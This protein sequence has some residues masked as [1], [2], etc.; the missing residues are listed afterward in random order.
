LINTSAPVV[1]TPGV[2]AAHYTKPTADTGY[3]LPDY[4][5]IGDLPTA[6]RMA[7]P[8]KMA[9]RGEVVDSS[10]GCLTLKTGNGALRKL[11]TM[12]A[13]DDL[14]GKEVT[15]WGTAT[16]GGA[17]GAGASLLVSHAVYAERWPAN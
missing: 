4:S 14:V 7:P 1:L 15:V 17:C 5:K 9:L 10:D 8:R 13:A 16:S 11:S 6:P 12:Q 2:P 3:R